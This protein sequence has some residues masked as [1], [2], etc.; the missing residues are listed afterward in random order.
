[1]PAEVGYSSLYSTTNEASKKVAHI[2]AVSWIPVNCLTNCWFPPA[3]PLVCKMICN[4]FVAILGVEYNQE[5]EEVALAFRC[6]NV[7]SVCEEE[8][9]CLSEEIVLALSDK[10]VVYYAK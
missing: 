4:Q 3:T 8:A 7:G 10:I 9:G 6:S 2:C 1:M 5:T